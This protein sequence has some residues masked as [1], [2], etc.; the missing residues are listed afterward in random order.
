MRILLIILSLFVVAHSNAGLLFLK[1]PAEYQ[2]MFEDLAQNSIA[3]GN[4]ML[5]YVPGKKMVVTPEA[6]KVL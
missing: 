4:I 6:K 1:K 5:L 2:Q 3:N